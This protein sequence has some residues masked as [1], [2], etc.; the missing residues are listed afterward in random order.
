MEVCIVST[1]TANVASVEAWL[2]RAGASPR[3]TLDPRDIDQAP[4]LVLPGVGAFG[5]AMNEL[6]SRGLVGSLR[7]RIELGRPTLAICLGM[8]LLMSSSDE[9]PGVPGLGVIPGNARRL[10]YGVRVPHMGWNRV[11]TSASSCLLQTGTAY[12]ANSFAVFDPPGSWAACRTDHGIRFISAIERGPVVAC[13]FH[14]ELS[15]AYG[16]SLLDRWLALASREVF[17]C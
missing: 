4:A 14:P 9:S 10:P 8:Q 13:Q 5:A 12:F 7:R 1:G 11:E 2:R 17:S 3:V 6:R 16:S 15:G